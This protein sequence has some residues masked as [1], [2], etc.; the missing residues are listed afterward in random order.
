[1]L[2][3]GLGF[4]RARFFPSEA[5]GKLGQLKIKAI[6]RSG[7]ILSVAVFQAERRISRT[8]VFVHARS[9]R[10]L[11]KTR[12]FGMTPYTNAENSN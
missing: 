11:V 7:V 6:A 4:M 8:S 12:A 5:G 1:M 9:L 2:H 10:P 3:L